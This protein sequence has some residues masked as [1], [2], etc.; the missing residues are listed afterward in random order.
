MSTIRKFLGTRTYA[1]AVKL[2][3][4]GKLEAALAKLE[5]FQGRIPDVAKASLLRAQVL[6][7]LGRFAEAM[8][9]F[10][11]FLLE[12]AGR[13]KAP[14]DQTYL[15]SMARYLQADAAHQSGAPP[16]EA[17]SRDEVQVLFEKASDKTR[18]EF[19]FDF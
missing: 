9:A 15:I 16:R 3:E 18:A 10:D 2:I 1:G 17:P 11:D 4:Q 12:H 6:Y 14:A 19:P 13:T 7:R 5:G 8:S